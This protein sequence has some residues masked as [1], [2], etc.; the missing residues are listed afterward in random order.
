MIN[1]AYA[2][3]N[4]GGGGAAGG[5]VDYG[6]MIVMTILFAIFYFLLIRPQQQKQKEV[7]EM[8]ANLA[9]G[10]TVLTSGGIHGKI[11]AITDTVVTLEI[12]EKVRIK[13]SRGFITA[14]VQKAGKE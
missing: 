14:V 12:A 9:H 11:V 8:L 1:T 10:D 2:M 13:V 5:G 6:F 7:K 4:L 3:G